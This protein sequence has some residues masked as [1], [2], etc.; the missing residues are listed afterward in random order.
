MV[1]E[2]AAPGGR[3]VELDGGGLLLDRFIDE[4]VGLVKAGEIVRVS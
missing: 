3:W 1:R 4:P 2:G